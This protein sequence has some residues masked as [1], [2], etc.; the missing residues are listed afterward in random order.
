MRGSMYS[1]SNA[2]CGSIL[3]ASDSTLPDTLPLPASSACW[4]R[5]MYMYVGD[6][7]QLTLGVM[8]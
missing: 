7:M 1:V 5:Y 6:N 3:S 2:R 4:R 8:L